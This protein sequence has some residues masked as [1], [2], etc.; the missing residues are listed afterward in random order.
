MA[1][2]REGLKEMSL[3]SPLLWPDM[4]HRQSKRQLLTVWMSWTVFQ[5]MEAVTILKL[6]KSAHTH[7][8]TQVSM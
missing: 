7:T 1:G 5:V 2:I 6:S 4:W 3:V 8:L